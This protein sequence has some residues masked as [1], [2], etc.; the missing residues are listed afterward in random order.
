MVVLG[1]FNL[2]HLLEVLKQ[3]FGYFCIPAVEGDDVSLGAEDFF[4]E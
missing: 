2:E 4:V 3:S 1:F